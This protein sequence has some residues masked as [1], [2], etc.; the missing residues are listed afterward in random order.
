[1]LN[2]SKYIKFVSDI[3][4]DVYIEIKQIKSECK[5]DTDLFNS[6]IHDF[7]RN[8]PFNEIVSN[9]V[10]ADS[11][12]CAKEMK[13]FLKGQIKE[14]E[15]LYEEKDQQEFV[16]KMLEYFEFS[17]LKR[18]FME[19]NDFSFL[20]EELLEQKY[21]FLKDYIRGEKAEKD[22]DVRALM[23]KIISNP[24]EVDFIGKG[25]LESSPRLKTFACHILAKE[26]EQA[27]ICENY[28]RLKEIEEVKSSLL[29]RDSEVQEDFNG[30]EQ[31]LHQRISDAIAEDMINF[32]NENN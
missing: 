26:R 13:K 10:K 21:D 22:E 29:K 3:L 15:S 14:I 19:N 16:K 17:P 8:S 24:G 25:A 7:V 1:M 12:I 9:D 18:Y 4:E 23:E 2:K 32:E 28:E 6:E 27:R 30:G 11:F 5:D 31:H 20:V